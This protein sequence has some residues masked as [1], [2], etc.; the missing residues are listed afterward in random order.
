[1]NDLLIYLLEA[2]VCL[3][4]SLLFYKL[5]LSDLTFFGWN[6]AVLLS[7]LGL[8]LLIPMLSFELSSGPAV[9]QEITLPEYWVGNPL[10]QEQE[11]FSWGQLLFYIYLIGMVWTA[12]RLMYG[13]IQ[14]FNLLGK[15]ELLFHKDQFIA[16]HP[17]FTPASFFQY[18][19][20]PKFQME[21]EDQQRII[22]HESIHVSK[23]H[24][25]D[26]LF[27]QMAKVVFWFNPLIYLFENTI[28]EVHE[29][30]ADQGVTNS[31]SHSEYSRLLL[32]LLTAGRGWQFMN[33]FNQFQTK[34]RI[35]M[36]N[37]TKSGN[38]QKGRFLWAVPV[39]GLLFFAFSCD[40]AQVEEELDGP[41][42]NG[43]KEVAVGIADLKARIKDVGKDGGEIFDVVET[44]PKPPGG[45]QGWNEYLSTNLTY[46]EQ[47]RRMGVE[48]TVI[49]VF[50]VNKDGSISNVDILRGIGAGADEEAIRVVQNAPNWTPGEQSGKAINTRMRLPIRFKLGN[51]EVSV[52]PSQVTDGFPREI[53]VPISN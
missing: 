4:V 15:S 5:V 24:S 38:N 20:L 11:S 16:V 37:R 51:P 23:R 53:E 46:P 33:N 42:Q 27:V 34:K 31:F 36:M 9:M 49:V 6:R 1:M 41:V 52:N 12:V 32:R 18:I 21:D 29:F 10:V 19:L 17:E 14:S 13:F 40:L 43:E 39:L 8:S 30:Q 48:G 2:S 45:M 50:V 22:L 26:L 7:M 47:A 25:Y 44:Q 3:A 35:I 28:R